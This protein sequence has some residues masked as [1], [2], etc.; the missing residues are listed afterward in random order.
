MGARAV[1]DG[2]DLRWS[3][4]AV[5]GAGVALPLLG[6]PGPGCPLR[7]ATG[8]PCP[9]CGMSTSVS[10]T[11]RGDVA[12]AM[13]AAPAGIVLVLLAL[14]LVVTGGPRRV[15]LP[16]PTIVATLMFMWLFQ[17]LRFSVL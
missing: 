7:S 10:A 16:M 17:L 8:I 12:E 13:T 14:W 15:E 11:V 4:L 2:G 9:L 5:L 3:A 1:V 6:N